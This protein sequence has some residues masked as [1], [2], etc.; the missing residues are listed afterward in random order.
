M[1]HR[2]FIKGVVQGVGFRPYVYRKAKAL[3]LKGF[4]RN[5]GNGVE[6]VVDDPDFMSR[7]TDLPP[8]ASIS[9]FE[10]RKVTLKKELDDFLI[11]KSELSQGETSLPPD[12]FMCDDCL[13]ELRDESDRRHDYYFITC[14][15]CG[16]RFSMIKDYPYDR[17]ATSMDEFRMCDDCRK[18]YENP[19]DRRYHA[20]TIACKECGP[21][22]KLLEGVSERKLASD[23]ERIKETAALLRGGDFVAVKGVGG[24]HLCAFADGKNAKR[25]RLEKAGRKDKPFALMVRDL[26]AARKIA[27]LSKAEED[28]L[29]SPKRPI[30]VVQKR[31]KDSFMAVS[32]L[33]SVGVMLPYTSLHYMLFDEIDEPLVM[34]SCNASDEPVAI[35][36]NEKN[37][38]F[39]LTHEREIINRCDDS[40]LKVVDDH[41][42]VLRRSRGFVPLPI[43]ISVPEACGG[44]LAVGAEMN[45]AFCIVK[46]GNA[47]LSQYLGNTARLENFNFM[48][49]S[50]KQWA[51]LTRAAPKVVACDLHPG[52][53]S[54]AFA[55]EAAKIFGARLVQVQHHK[56][57][58]A[59]VAAEHGV[60]D[61]VGIAMDGLGFG[62]DGGIWGGEVFKVSGGFDFVRVGSLEEQPQLGGDSATIYPKKML[63]GILSKFLDERSLMGLGLFDEKE[64]RLYLKMLKDNYNVPLTT[65]AG[66][67]LDA[68]SALLGFCDERTYDGRPAMILES[69]ASM[70]YALEP[71]IFKQVGRR[72]LSTTALFKFIYENRGEDKA[73]LAATAQSYLAKG[74]FEIARLEAKGL[75]IV[76]SGGV[77]YNRMISGFMLKNKVLLN[78]EVPAGDGGV[79]FGQAY[80]AGLIAGKD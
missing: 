14:T 47:Y 65:S 19:L 23:K 12:I 63:F 51:R 7:L 70:P 53:N 6:V 49:E 38:R 78:K 11:L 26:E 75:P 35:V 37:S 30:V 8:L 18:E 17:P 68:V 22:L 58:V 72:I 39:H 80:L 31:D 42:L 16:P 28:L 66:R 3:G 54:T 55:K 60:L 10:E 1:F 76:F 71:L 69:N 43:P 40:V 61:Y 45:N 9:S 27:V 33:G 41:P 5:T 48:K 77:A 24:F 79:C 21:K 46:N 52:Y 34:T 32:E 62:D 13:Q 57:H 74:L 73:R 59:S 44:I 15:N 64:T 29:V 20:Q 67:V 4:V 36:E 50:V 2:F 25:L 56:A